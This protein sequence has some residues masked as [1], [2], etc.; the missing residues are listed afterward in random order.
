LEWRVRPWRAAIYDRG[1]AAV[2]AVAK[3]SLILM[4]GE[5][6]SERRAG[7][8]GEPVPPGRPGR[9]DHHGPDDPWSGDVLEPALTAQRGNGPPPRERE[10]PASPAPDDALAEAEAELAPRGPGGS[11]IGTPQAEQETPSRHQGDQE[12]LRALRAAGFEGIVWEY[13][14]NEL[15]AYAIPVLMSWTR[16]GKIVKLC[17]AWGMRIAPPRNWSH[18]DR[19]DVAYEATARAIKKFRGTL[20]QEK[21]DPGRGASIKTYFMG[22]VIKE[23]PNSYHRWRN[24]CV[25]PQDRPGPQA[26]EDTPA[27]AAIQ[28]PRVRGDPAEL[29]TDTVFVGELLAAM[30]PELRA[31]SLMLHGGSS[32]AEAAAAIDKTPGALREQ[33]RR[34]G[35]KYRKEGG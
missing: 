1:N 2:L 31:A 11:A 28:P 23:F 20:R 13:F 33:L 6:Y 7:K 8:P 30:P 4:A 5:S 32:V 10:D 19:S 15:A 26:L 18:Q 16:T 17:A 3:G 24:A 14:A 12:L 34:F 27:V 35:R 21:W 29:A 25:R 9:E 22:A